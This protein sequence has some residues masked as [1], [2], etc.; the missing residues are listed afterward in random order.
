MNWNKLENINQ[1][2]LIDEESKDKKI[3]L[4]K[5]STRCS[6]SSMALDRLERNWKEEDY[7][8]IKCCYIEVLQH[9]GISDEIAFRYKVIHESPQV[10]LI[11]NSKC[12]YHKSQSE[13]NY[14]EIIK[15]V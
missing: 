2:A 6:I 1:L 5:H 9:R 10:L 11:E 3:L 12:I 8:K 14:S 7:S 4:F 13:I 15:L